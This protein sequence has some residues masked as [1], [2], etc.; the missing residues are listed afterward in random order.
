VPEWRYG[1]FVDLLAPFHAAECADAQQEV[2]SETQWD[3]LGLIIAHDPRVAPD[4]GAKRDLIIESL[5]QKAAGR[6]VKLDGQESGKRKR[7]HR[8]FDGGARA[9]FYHAVCEV[10]LARIVRV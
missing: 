1:E 10:H 8:L 6:A 5:E 2:L 4:A 3:K 7:G 9:S